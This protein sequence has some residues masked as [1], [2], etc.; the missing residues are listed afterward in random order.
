[1]VIG[2]ELFF[3]VL[4]SDVFVGTVSLALDLEHAVKEKHNNVDISN[5]P[6]ALDK[7]FFD[8]IIFAPSNIVNTINSIITIYVI[9][10]HVKLN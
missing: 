9:N 2:F 4:T 7:S 6:V 5:A 10:V 3:L 1:M 8:F